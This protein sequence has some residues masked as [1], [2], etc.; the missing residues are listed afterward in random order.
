M[1]RVY[2]CA[3]V[4]GAAGVIERQQRSAVCTYMCIGVCVYVP[5][6]ACLNRVQL[7][8]TCSTAGCCDVILPP[9][10]CVFTPLWVTA[11]QFSLWGYVFVHT[12]PNW[13]YFKNVFCQCVFMHILEELSVQQNPRD[14]EDRGTDSPP[15]SLPY[16]QKLI[17]N[18]E[19]SWSMSS[20]S[21]SGSRNALK[22]RTFASLCFG[23]VDPWQCISLL[24]FD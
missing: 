14:C 3:R 6:C 7:Q 9:L 1:F 19:F 20:N 12:V 10:R 2:L 21:L 11:L 17:Y 22:S 5:L 18:T 23:G 13:R 8:S 16:A 4:V 15:A 24:H